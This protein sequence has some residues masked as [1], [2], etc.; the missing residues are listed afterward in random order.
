VFAVPR[1]QSRRRPAL[2]VL[3][4]VTLG[5]LTS[6]PGVAL[7]DD[8]VAAG[9]TVVGELVQGYS[10][11]GP[12]TP[13][14]AS[15]VDDGP[16]LLSWI[17]TDD[18]DAVRVPTSDV[19]DVPVGATVEVTVGR[20]VHD[21]ASAGGL[22]PARDV[23][24][25]EV[26]AEASAPEPVTSPAVTPIAHQVT[27]VM[28]R[29]PGAPADQTSLTDVQAT[30]EGTVAGF[31]SEQ[32]GGRV[33]ISVVGGWDWAPATVGCANPF[34]LWQEAAD[35]AGWSEGAGQHLLVYVPYGTPGCSYGLGT[36]GS[37]LDGG[38]LAYV[39]AARTSVIAHEF[40]HNIGLGHSSARQCDSAVEVGTCQVVGYGDYYDVMGI[41]WEQVG[42]LN[43]AQAARLGVLQQGVA[44]G[45]A[46]LTD[47]GQGGTVTLAPVA[48]ST[49]TRG[50]RLVDTDGTVYWLENRQP[51]GRDD[52][53]GSSA[54]NWPGL[55]SGVTLRQERTGADTSL[56]LDGTPSTRSGWP[57]D[58]GVALPVGTAVPVAQGDFW[59]TVRSVDGAGAVL[60]V[61]TAA[62][63]RAQRVASS[64]ASARART[65]MLG[66]ESLTSPNGRFQMVFQSDGN[67]VVYGGGRALWASATA[68]AGGRFLVQSD[69]NMVVYSAS[70]AAVWSSRTSSV[71]GAELVMQDDG[72]LV[73]YRST[74]A[75]WSSGGDRR[76]RL[77]SGQVLES[78]QALVSANGGYHAIMQADGNLVV[79]GAGARVVWASGS[80][81]QGGS[82]VSQADGN[83]VV[84]TTTGAAAW[85]T[86]TSAAGATLL[87]Q[88]DGNLVLY[89]PAGPLWASNAER[90][91]VLR[92]GRALQSTQALVSPNGSY[93]LIMQADGN[94]VVYRQD[95]AVRYASRTAASGPRLLMQQDGNA[96]IYSAQGAAIWA[97]GTGPDSAASLVMQDDGNLVVYRGNGTPAWVAR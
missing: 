96:V 87:M 75:A 38:G 43:L 68:A 22:E 8:G 51:T 63:A 21:E 65:T 7:A 85:A 31:W 88:D 94:L 13:G 49:G 82:L 20:T 36:V 25:S 3:V 91:Q 29:P 48:G 16:G 17:Q 26:V 53:L 33:Q 89:G 44:G 32:T 42:T 23:V 12:A 83:V 56:L 70:G 47:S 24:S 4:G 92:A 62:D 11:P 54:L 95:G 18:G 15:A 28:M 78:T 2:L 77:S 58:H 50:L 37:G 57:A 9:D 14:D 39:Q 34:A 72:N 61:T 80:V 73:L 64:V 67:L 10:D 74:G 40:G 69:G 55:Q 97:T 52:W 86:G 6:V 76:D 81:A 1:P 19:D 30:V 59:V 41:S 45:Y 90:S 46:E 84:Y 66:G 27:V 35:R 60:A 71:G 93:R 5:V 79:Y